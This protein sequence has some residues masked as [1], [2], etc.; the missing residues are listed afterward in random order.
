M[1]EVDQFGRDELHHAAMKDDVETIRARLDAGVDVNLPES[2]QGFQ[3]LHFAIQEG[4]AEAVRVLLE[5]GADIQATDTSTK[6]PLHMAVT[7]WRQS[8]DGDVI[9]LLIEHGA[10]KAATDRNDMTPADFAD[11]QWE[12]PAELR[13]LL[14]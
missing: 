6:T 8:P 13:E 10:D 9:K 7:R 12:F 14:T 1:S 4:A 5:A 2:R 11:G 3:P